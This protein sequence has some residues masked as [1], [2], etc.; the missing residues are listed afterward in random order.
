MSQEE[1]QL[2][3]HRRVLEGF[4]PD[5]GSWAEGMKPD[6]EGGLGYVG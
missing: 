3:L 5:F 1:L 6:T 4:G 2:R